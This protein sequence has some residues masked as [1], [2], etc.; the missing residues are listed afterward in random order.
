MDTTDLIQIL[1]TNNG[2]PFIIKVLNE[3]NNKD[4]NDLEKIILR[5]LLNIYIKLNEQN[6]S[7]DLKNKIKEL[8]KDESKIKEL[9]KDESKINKLIKDSLNN[10]YIFYTYKVFNSIVSYTNLFN[11]RIK[12]ELFD[13]YNI[14]ETP[15]IQ[16]E[17]FNLYKD[18]YNSSYLKNTHYE[19]IKKNFKETIEK[20]FEN[21]FI[22]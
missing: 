10:K 21:K 13:N 12:K 9:I 15:I 11:D 20:L 22:N 17:R 4:L 8:I 5:D 14:T 18:I 6:I 2:N 3:V 7:E 1:T 19:Q 16:N